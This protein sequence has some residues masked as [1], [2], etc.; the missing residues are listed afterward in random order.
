M[1]L[2]KKRTSLLHNKEGSS[3]DAKPDGNSF[4]G[5]LMSALGVSGVN[6]TPASDDTVDGHII[7]K[8]HESCHDVEN[9]DIDTSTDS[10]VSLKLPVLMPSESTVT[11]ITESSHTQKESMVKVLL[12]PHPSFQVDPEQENAKQTDDDIES[13]NVREVFPECSICLA[14][15]VQSE[16]VSWSPNK[17]CHHCFHHD[18]LETWF[19]TLARRADARRGK[20]SYDIEC[21]LNC[22][23]CRQTFISTSFDDTEEEVIDVSSD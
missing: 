6:G 22:P 14:E 17:A 1:K 2:S 18:C 10:M 21:E 12:L 20:R 4:T 19:M 23:I 8:K 9:D 16:K 11:D 13:Q 7:M 3:K 15:C 5:L